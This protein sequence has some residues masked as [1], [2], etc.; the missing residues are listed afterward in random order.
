ME[1]IS[2]KIEQTYISIS[3]ERREN[4]ICYILTS[5]RIYLPQELVGK[6]IRT[7][8]NKLAKLLNEALEGISGNTKNLAIYL[9]AKIAFFASYEYKSNLSNSAK[10]RRR[11]EEENRIIGNLEEKPLIAKYDF[12]GEFEGYDNSSVI[13]TDS[14]FVKAL[15]EAMDAYGYKVVLVSSS[16]VCY[17]E[18]MKPIVR[19]AGR[20]IAL[21][22]NKTGLNVVCFE[23]GEPVLLAGREFPGVSLD[24]GMVASEV[25]K[26]VDL[27]VPK[28]R[29]ILTGFLSGE[30]DL[31]SVFTSYPHVVYCQPLSFELK[32]AQK[33]IA[34]S[35]KLAGRENMLAGVFTA[36]GADP[37]NP[38][39]VNFIKTKKDQFQGSKGVIALCVVTLIIVFGVALAPVFN[40]FFEQRSYDKNVAKLMD[41]GYASVYEKISERRDLTMQFAELNTSRALIPTQSISY[42]SLV[43]ELKIALLMDATVQEITFSEGE[44]VMIDFIT[45]NAKNYDEMKTVIESSGRMQIIEQIE[46]E[47]S[48]VGNTTLTH[49]QIKVL[50][51]NELQ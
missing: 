42:S 38:H 32:G 10:A 9:G 13:V 46:R 8:P 51:G 44:G 25:A 31:I 14:G 39:L 12:N 49:I 30:Q 4:D 29:I 7:K 18:T 21:D 17:A 36:L 24:A 45:N 41:G 15:T 47:E 3:Y 19:G 33:T 6:N 28:T 1:I 2:I 22:I 43:E 40:L 35:G 16:L 50:A 34:F 20:V 5:Q 48:K 11:I 27:T 26:I 23:K 37:T